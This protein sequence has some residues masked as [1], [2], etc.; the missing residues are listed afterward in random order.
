MVAEPVDG[1]LKGFNV[2]YLHRI[3]LAN[4]QKFGEFG[5]TFFDIIIYPRGKLAAKRAQNFRP[6]GQVKFPPRKCQT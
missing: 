4:V 1:A 3:Q 5:K 2:A 6:F